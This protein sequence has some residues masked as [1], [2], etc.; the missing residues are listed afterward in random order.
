MS[1]N[2]ALISS[3]VISMM[4][5]GV[6][7]VPTSA[8][9]QSTHA[10]IEA[11]GGNAAA[12]GESAQDHFKSALEAT[13]RG[14][15]KLAAAQIRQGALPVS[16]EFA[17][18]KGDI[19]LGLERVS[20]E[21]DQAANALENGTAPSRAALSRTFARAD[22][23]LALS[24]H[25]NAALAWSEA[26]AR[27]AGHKLMAAS[28]ELVSAAGW[29]G[30]KLNAGVLSLD[31]GSQSIANRLAEGQNWSKREVAAAFH[32]LGKALDDLGRKIGSHLQ[33]V[34][35]PDKG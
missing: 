4:L 26:S 20:A 10:A 18:A 8:A 34:P 19:K 25:V 27:A 14:D 5:L 7:Q 24:H 15:Y 22:H 31:A 11:R 6:T 28:R 16:I 35:F 9:A 12:V 33:A 2:H 13:T 30:A 1:T 17:R 23:A 29:A 32:T 21:L 3:A